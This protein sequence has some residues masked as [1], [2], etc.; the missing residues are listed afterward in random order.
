MI[1]EVFTGAERR[2]SPLRSILSFM[3]LIMKNWLVKYR[4]KMKTKMRMIESKGSG[5]DIWA[6]VLKLPMVLVPD[7]STSVYRLIRVSCCPERTSSARI[8]STVYP[9]VG[10]GVGTSFTSPEG[11]GATPRAGAALTYCPD[12]VARKSSSDFT[13]WVSIQSG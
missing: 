10:D 13:L 8:S 7:E 4:G 12:W 2:I 9:S 6:G 5:G 11:T 1:E 3:M